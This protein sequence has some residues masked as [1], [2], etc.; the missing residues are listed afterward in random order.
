MAS[1]LQLV[2]AGLAAI[3]TGAAAIGVGIIFGISSMARCAIRR[4][5]RPVHQRHH[6]RGPCEGLG[7]FAFLIAIL[8]YLK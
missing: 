2:G 1:E 7:I 8:L 3:G 5:R 6:R 4:R